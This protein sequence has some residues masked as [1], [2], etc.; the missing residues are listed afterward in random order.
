MKQYNGKT[1]LFSS[2]MLILLFVLVLLT[3]CAP[4]AKKNNSVN[5]IADAKT[6]GKALGCMFG[7]CEPVDQKKSQPTDK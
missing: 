6:I 1:F 3:S 4:T 2:G 5:P 7:G